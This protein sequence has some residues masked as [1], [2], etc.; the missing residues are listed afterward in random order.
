ME[1]YGHM[2]LFSDGTLHHS[3]GI[4]FYYVAGNASFQVSILAKQITNWHCEEIFKADVCFTMFLWKSGENIK[5][6]QIMDQ[7]DLYVIF[8]MFQ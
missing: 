4:N 7:Y 6:K 3:A 5:A 2:K 8:H 1:G